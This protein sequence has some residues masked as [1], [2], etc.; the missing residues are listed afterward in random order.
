MKTK[1]AF[2]LLL[3]ISISA[4]S[5]DYMGCKFGV[6]TAEVKTY[7]DKVYSQTG[8]IAEK[9]VVYSNLFQNGEYHTVALDCFGGTF[10]SASI[11][12]F[13]TGLGAGALK[14]SSIYSSFT[15]LY[16]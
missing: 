2:L 6:S 11:Q 10:E 12:Y 15:K 16:G 14:Y 8:E 7:F 5:Q 13:T 9:V 4:F 3:F 1:I